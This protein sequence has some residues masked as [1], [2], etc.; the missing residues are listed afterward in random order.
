MV[1]KICVQIKEKLIIE[2]NILTFVEY[3]QGLGY[4][5]FFDS[6]ADIDTPQDEY[7][8]IVPEKE[9]GPARVKDVVEYFINKHPEYLL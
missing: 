9:L 6:S 5:I 8:C 2:Y 1:D 4:K 7:L 3:T